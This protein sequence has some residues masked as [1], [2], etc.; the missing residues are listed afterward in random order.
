MTPEVQKVFH[1]K[2]K[3]LDCPTYELDKE[4]SI[5]ENGEIFDFHYKDISI[6]NITLSM[7]GHDQRTNA[8][9]AAM[10]AIIL[11]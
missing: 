11:K 2:T 6:A 4:F 7:L 1:Q 10:A 8:S 3:E 9:L 5:R